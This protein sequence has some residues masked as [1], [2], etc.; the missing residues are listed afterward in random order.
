MSSLMAKTNCSLFLN[1]FIS[2]IAGA[3]AVKIPG[4]K[5]FPKIDQIKRTYDLFVKSIR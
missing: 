2:Q 5:D 4:N 1:L 3:L